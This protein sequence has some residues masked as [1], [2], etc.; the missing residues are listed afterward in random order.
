MFWKTLL[1]IYIVVTVM[2]FLVGLFVIKVTFFDWSRWK[3][4]GVIAVLCLLWPLV[5]VIA[6]VIGIVN[7]IKYR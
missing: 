6:I 3:T 5:A 2:A 4:Y 7:A 1:I